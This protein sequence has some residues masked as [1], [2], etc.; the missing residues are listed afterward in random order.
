MNRPGGTKQ[1]SAQQNLAHLDVA[2]RW[3]TG[4]LDQVIGQR[5]PNE[6][7]RDGPSHRHVADGDHGLVRQIRQR[8]GDCWRR[9]FACRVQA[10]RI[11]RELMRAIEPRMR[12]VVLS[13]MPSNR[14]TIKLLR[15]RRR[16]QLIDAAP[17]RQ[18]EQER[19]GCFLRKRD[20][21]AAFDQCSHQP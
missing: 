11:V 21:G 7:A 12:G 14:L 16:T 13:D 4:K 17:R 3:R 15:N 8:T 2:R 10:G 19:R 9:F 5:W 20:V 6:I 18:R 1:P